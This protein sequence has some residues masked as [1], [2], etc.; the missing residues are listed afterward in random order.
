ML[1]CLL[2]VSIVIDR[3]L[4]IPMLFRGT[5]EGKILKMERNKKYKE[6][7]DEKKQKDIR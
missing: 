6:L 5:K 1:T 2:F 7:R 4:L 3:V